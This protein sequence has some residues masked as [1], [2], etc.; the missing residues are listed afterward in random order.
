MTETSLMAPQKPDGSCSEVWTHHV[1]N[2]NVQHIIYWCTT[3]FQTSKRAAVS[4]DC[5]ALKED[6]AVLAARPLRK[7]TALP[8]LLYSLT[9]DSPKVA[10]EFLAWCT[11]AYFGHFEC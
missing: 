6:D 8:L 5:A 7:T 9:D 1:S 2:D 11:E 10:T 4:A 3:E